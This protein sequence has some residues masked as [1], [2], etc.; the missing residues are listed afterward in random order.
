MLEV[1]LTWAKKLC[2]LKEVGRVLAEGYGYR[3]DN[4]VLDS[5]FYQVWV[6]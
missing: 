6:F 3:F 5:Y 4:N 2:Y 1:L